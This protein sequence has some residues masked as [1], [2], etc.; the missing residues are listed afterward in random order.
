MKVLFVVKDME[1]ESIGVM[2]LSAVL[3]RAGHE[4]FALCAR[5]EV[6]LMDRIKEIEPD[7]IGYSTTTGMHSY[8]LRLNEELK[9]RFD[10]KS[11]FGGPHPTFFPEI[12]ERDGVD[13]VCV[14]E[15]EDAIVEYVNALSE[16]G[17][18]AGIGNI[19]YKEGSEI[20]RNELRPF[21]ED[22]DTIP[23]PDREIFRKYYDKLPAPY[24]VFITG[25]GC[26][27]SC[28]Y[29]FNH[30]LKKMFDGRYIRHRSVALIIKEINEVKEGGDLK[31]CGFLDD[32]FTVNRRWLMDFCK[33]YETDV[34]IPFFCHLR[35][36]LVD[37]DVARMLSKAGCIAGVIGVE[38]G[39]YKARK[40]IL[41]KDIKNEEILSASHLLKKNGIRVITQNMVGIPE[42][43]P[44]NVLKMAKINSKIGSNHMNLY[45]YQPYPR[46]DL[47]ELSI[48]R[49]LYNGDVDKIN[50]SY[51][52]YDS[53]IIL[54]LEN[55]KDLLL[56][57]SLFHLAVRI[58]FVQG[59]ISFLLK[60][61]LLKNLL[62]LLKPF[63]KYFRKKD[64]LKVDSL[65]H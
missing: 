35:A 3:K 14:G 31:I 43:T 63:D 62:A 25:R 37:E 57:A 42:D 60:V 44:E 38:T 23:F 16:K 10:F 51:S 24:R 29:C 27:F 36:D 20:V 64:Y 7:V 9:N 48:E 2:T 53:D 4:T 32:T 59:L 1:Y 19:Y 8:Y 21:I 46:T 56:V 28:S 6:D 54:A 33:G 15:G 13:A 50:P 17:E 34:S 30:S 39:S 58:P 11:I 47:C 41:K 49:G 55:K 18:L 52:A 40:D 5:Y 45:F 61:P 26:P 22:L 12:I 65:I